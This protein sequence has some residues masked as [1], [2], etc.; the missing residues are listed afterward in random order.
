MAQNTA[1]KDVLEQLDIVFLN[2]ERHPF[3]NTV[4]DGEGRLRSNLQTFDSLVNH[5]ANS[6]LDLQMRRGARMR[7]GD[8]TLPAATP[9]EPHQITDGI[10]GTHFKEEPAHSA[11][12][13]SMAVSVPSATRRTRAKRWASSALSVDS[14]A[15]AVEVS[16]DVALSDEPALSASSAKCATSTP[17]VAKRRKKEIFDSWQPTEIKM[18][19]NALVPIPVVQQ[20]PP[21]EVSRRTRT[22][23]SSVAFATPCVLGMRVQT[24][25]HWLSFTL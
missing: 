11:A 19:E 8:A 16:M 4:F 14:G 12:P 6:C 21:A 3:Y 22:R 5:C 13:A 10:V 1:V 17:T 23:I 20:E 24:R 15:Q 25:T 9:R 2:C 18:L 7:V